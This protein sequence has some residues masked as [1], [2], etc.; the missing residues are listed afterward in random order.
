[1]FPFPCLTLL[2]MFLREV[3]AIP[4]LRDKV[5]RIRSMRDTTGGVYYL[6][7]VPADLSFGRRLGGLNRSNFLVKPDNS[8]VVVWIL[9][10]ISALRFT[11]DE[12]N[13]L[14]HLFVGVQT[15]TPVDAAASVRLCNLYSSPTH[16]EFTLFYRFRQELTVL[17]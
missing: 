9:G 11:D 7:Q 13:L 12:G 15:L 14:R 5:A 3:P 4:P 2:T 1:M 8:P 10:R 6:T 16:C 17:V